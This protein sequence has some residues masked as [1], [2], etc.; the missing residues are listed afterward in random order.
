MENEREVEH[1]EIE[2][3][4]SERVW[5]WGEIVGIADESVRG[6]RKRG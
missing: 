3:V 4:G 6:E 2:C 5:G 1:G